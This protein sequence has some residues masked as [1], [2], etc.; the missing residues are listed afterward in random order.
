M[1][2]HVGIDIGTTNTKCLVMDTNGTIV[3]RLTDKTPKHLIHSLEFFDV[4]RIDSLIDSFITEVQSKYSIRSIGY[5]SIGESVIPIKNGKICFDCP[6]WS[7]ASIT[8]TP[9]QRDIMKQYCGF[10]NTGTVHNGLF[11]LDKILWMRDHFQECREVDLWLPMT[12]YQV[13]RKTGEGVWDYTQASRSYMFNVHTKQWIVPLLEAFNMKEPGRLAMIGTAVSG[14]DG[15][16]HGIGGHD[17]MVGLFGIEKIF[18]QDGKSIPLFYDSMGTSAVLTMISG[19]ESH[20]DISDHITYNPTGGCLL[21]G[22]SQDS[23]ILTRSFRMFGSLLAYVKRIGQ[24]GISN[25]QFQDINEMLLQ[26]I[27]TQCRTLI[28][29]D[30]DFILGT[31]GTGEVN[32]HNVDLNGDITSLLHNTYLYLASL[33][34][35]MQDDLYRFSTTKKA[36]TFISGGGITDN[37]L[38]MEYLATACNCRITVL[39]TAEISALGAL[40]VGLVACKDDTMLKIVSNLQE[41]CTFVEPSLRLKPAIKDARIQYLKLRETMKS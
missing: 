8:S 30:G 9:H 14:K 21:P 32:F 2:C 11:S 29:C 35:L 28:T 1:N 26:C 13:Y 4:H 16:V 18:S 6:L 5:S 17:H 33:T 36:L 23:F 40:I 34:K 25:Y 41:R 37:T 7:V 38:F 24:Q 27:P 22:F 10:E 12:A 20:V 31:T 3:L 19:S 39:P 15:I